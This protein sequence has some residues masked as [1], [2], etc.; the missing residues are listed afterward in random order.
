MIKWAGWLILLFPGVGHSLGALLE[1]APSH[2]S[3]W[4]DGDGWHTDATEMTHAQATLWYTV[5]SFGIPFLLLGLLILWLAY[6]GITP[7]S[8]IAWGI[9]AWA[10]VATA[11]GGPSPLLVLF[12]A[13]ALLLLGAKRAA[14]H[15]QSDPEPAA[16]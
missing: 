1:T 4:F 11:A 5:G 7:P 15:D 8:F 10:A 2:A 9:A 12:V 3:A 16:A 14:R 6:R 13:A